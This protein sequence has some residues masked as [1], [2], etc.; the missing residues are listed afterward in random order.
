MLPIRVQTLAQ[1]ARGAAWRLEL[2]HA[3]DDHLLIW[4]TRGQGRLLLDGSRRGIGTH[5]AIFVPAGHLF[6][7]DLGWQGAGQALVIPAGSDIRLP[8]TPQHLR[9]R[10]AAPIAELNA[11]FDACGRESAG[12]R[13][14]KHEAIAAQATLMS[15]WLRRQMAEP[16]HFDPPPTPAQRLVQRYCA[17]LAQR[18]A[19]GTETM[20]DHAAALAVSPTHLARVCKAATGRTA[21]DLATECL[22]YAARDAL[23]ATAA[24]AQDIAR[25]L[26][27]GSAAYFTRFMRAR[28]G[29]TPTQIRRAAASAPAR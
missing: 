17:R 29:Q 4:I 16:G 22:L 10:E 7:L 13:A 20:A 8:E 18:S 9:L 2:A 23:E 28:T 26:G 1:L 5:N 21:A 6:A 19:P 24:P 25:H 12:T 11:L 14:L 3:R 15:V 27:F